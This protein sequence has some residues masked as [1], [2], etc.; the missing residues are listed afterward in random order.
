[1][2]QTTKKYHVQGHMQVLWFGVSK[3]EGLGY[4]DLDLTQHPFGGIDRRIDCDVNHFF[5]VKIETFLEKKFK[6]QNRLNF[7]RIV[8]EKCSQMV[9]DWTQILCD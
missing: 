2:S 8:K 6:S 3:I 1:M 5:R 7:I 9:F 4:C